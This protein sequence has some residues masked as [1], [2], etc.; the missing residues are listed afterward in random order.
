MG[1]CKDCVHWTHT[2]GDYPANSGFGKCARVRMFWK[3]TEWSED[4]DFLQIRSLTKE[5]DGDLAFVQ[6]A[7]DYC[8]EFITLRDFGCVQFEKK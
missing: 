4:K 8:A 7:S 3:C 2:K 5:A 1:N 6:D